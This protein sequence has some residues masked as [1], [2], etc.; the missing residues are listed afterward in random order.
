MA[1]TRTEKEKGY[2]IKHEG[3]K[4]QTY[5]GKAGAGERIFD[6]GASAEKA[7]EYISEGAEAAGE[8]ISEKGEEALDTIN[9]FLKGFGMTAKRAGG[10]N[11]KPHIMELPTNSSQKRKK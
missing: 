9:S 2:L 4:G 11:I 7:G 3:T 6:L 8:Y 1:A 10:T 5:Y